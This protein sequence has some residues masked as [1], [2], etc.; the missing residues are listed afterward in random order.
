MHSDRSI[1]FGTAPDGSPVRLL[2]L[3]NGTLS[4]SV[5]TYGAIL[6]SLR[7]P[8]RAGR[9]V[10]VVLGYDTLPEYT[11]QDGHL[12]ATIGRFANRIA[13]GRFT[14]NGVHYQLEVN[15]NGHHLH[16]GTH[17]YAKRVWMVEEHDAL[18]V[19]LSLDSPDG[20]SGYPG[21]MSVQMTYRLGGDALELRYRALCDR[22]TPCNL[23]NHTYFNLDGHGAGSALDQ[24][25]TLYASRYL[26]VGPDHVPLGTIEPVEGT[27]LD[28]RAPHTIRER[29]GADHIQLRSARG[30]DQCFLVDGTPGV[31]RPAARARSARTGI[32]LEAETTMPGLQFYSANYLTGR[33]GKGGA[34]YGYRGGFCLE[35][36]NC[37][38]APNRPNFPSCILKAG[39][40]LDQITRFRFLAEP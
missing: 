4:C 25:I 38:D 5:L 13:R 17:G 35:T 15:N 1:P 30:Y 31:L 21:H 10:D 22:D 32:V 8:D 29:I 7:V 2:T 20:D 39:E 26:P 37:P 34:R 27:P 28:F 16:S 18:H 36:E 3:D 19:T 24:E 40:P 23:T 11:G 6:Q 9:P 12:G 14:L 33:P